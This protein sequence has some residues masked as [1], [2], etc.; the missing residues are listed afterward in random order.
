MTKTQALVARTGPSS[1]AS[2]RAKAPA[3]VMTG[4]WTKVPR[5]PKKAQKKLHG[6]LAAR[7]R[8]RRSHIAIHSLRS[9]RTN[10]YTGEKVILA[11]R[12]RESTVL[13]PKDVEEHP[14]YKRFYSD[15]IE[16]QVELLREILHST[17]VHRLR[18]E[19]LA[20]LR[21][22]PGSNSTL[23]QL[24][25]TPDSND[26][27]ELPQEKVK[28]G[29]AKDRLDG[30]LNAPELK[31]MVYRLRN[32]LDPDCDEDKPLLA[33]SIRKLNRAELAAIAVSLLPRFARGEIA[34]TAL[35]EANVPE[36]KVWALLQLASNQPVPGLVLPNA[37]DLSNASGS[38]GEGH[39]A[40][41]QFTSM[42]SP[43]P[44]PQPQPGVLNDRLSLGS[45]FAQGN[46]LD[47]IQ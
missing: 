31:A 4:R 16:P 34:I 38:G 18:Q 41:D 13:C 27:F 28:A 23:A 33:M 20:R 26:M 15:H 32:K 5:V 25:V 44:S 42:P 2:R 3:L 9:Q 35:H 37:N 14:A 17:K 10:T 11:N 19:V 6:Y 47:P 7:F 1:W 22:N 40:H 12:R 39:G 21:A 46:S 8:I 24:P 36:H 43:T 30:Y 29:G 45:L